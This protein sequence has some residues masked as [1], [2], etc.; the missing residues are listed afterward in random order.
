MPIMGPIRPQDRYGTI[1]GWAKRAALLLVGTLSGGRRMQFVSA[2]TTAPD[3]DDA[4]QAL[5]AQV[6]AALPTDEDGCDLAVVFMSGHFAPRAALIAPRLREALG[7]RVL[8]GTSFEGVIGADAEL[9]RTPAMTLLA[10]RLPGVTVTPF[11]LGASAWGDLADPAAL[12]AR[13]NLPDDPRLLLILADPFSTPAEELLTAL[14]QTYPGVPVC[15]GMASGSM[16]PGGNALVLDSRAVTT[17]AVGLAL[18]GNIAVDLIVSPGCRPIGEPLTVTGAHRNLILTLDDV[19]ALPRLRR[20]ADTLD[21]ADRALLGSNLAIGRA[22][23]DPSGPLGRGDF[24]IRSVLGINPQRGGIAIGDIPRVGQVVQFQLR[25]AE[26]AVE[27]LAMLLLPHTFDAP[28]RGALLFSCNGR[29]TRLY[30]HPHGDLT[31]IRD[32]LGP[33]NLAGGFCAGEIG[34][35][36]G[37]AYLHGQTACLALFRPGTR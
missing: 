18:A 27:D 24:L 6:R 26:A 3:F 16:Q 34:T 10:A 29:G 32:A 12:R 22:I 31:A 33:L 9:E 23:G 4:I 28:P 35:I 21:P 19:P 2:T 37:R 36:S 1:G 8:I 11:A 30:D 15:G 7:T 20:L 17:G 25:D 13:L 14:D 5:V